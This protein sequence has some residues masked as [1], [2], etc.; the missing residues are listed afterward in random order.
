VS[1]KPRRM[2]LLLHARAQQY[3]LI[4]FFCGGLV[5]VAFCLTCILSQTVFK[6]TGFTIRTTHVYIRASE[7]KGKLLFT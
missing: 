3:Y 1:R 6:S 7:V 4:E 2:L 5:V